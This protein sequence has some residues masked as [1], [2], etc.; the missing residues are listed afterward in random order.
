[1]RSAYRVLLEKAWNFR[2]EELGMSCE[3]R[4]E[5]KFIYLAIS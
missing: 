3:D 1:L 5:N 4:S 2:V